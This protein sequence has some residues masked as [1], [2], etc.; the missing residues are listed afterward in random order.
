MPE[1]PG[2]AAGWAIRALEFQS[3]GQFRH[4][5]TPS[6]GVVYEVLEFGK[7]TEN[8]FQLTVREGDTTKVRVSHASSLDKA[9]AAANDDNEARVMAS[10]IEAPAKA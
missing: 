9:F 5:A 2:I 8:R 1:K 10:L 3:Y 4:L 7:W 6:S